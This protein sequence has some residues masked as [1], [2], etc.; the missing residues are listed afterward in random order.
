MVARKVV[1][2]AVVTV[3]GVMVVADSG[4]VMAAVVTVE[5]LA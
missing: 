1:M 4:G 5:A 2:A 3:E